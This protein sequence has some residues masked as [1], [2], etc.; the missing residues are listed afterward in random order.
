MNGKQ[1]DNNIISK[2]KILQTVTKVSDLMGLLS[3]FIIRAKILM[4]QIWI[5]NY[6]CDENLPVDLVEISFKW[7]SG[8]WGFSAYYIPRCV[9]ENSKNYVELHIFS[10]ACPQAYGAVAYLRTIDISNNINCNVLVA[11]NSVSPVD[12]KGDKE[13]TLPELEFTRAL[14]A[15]HCRNL[16]LII[17]RSNLIPV[18]CGPTLR[19]HLTGFEVKHLDRNPMLAIGW[20]RRRKFLTV[21]EGI[22]RQ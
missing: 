16:L 13:L 15:A 6:D 18:F 10:D 9:M 22:A 19:L 20:W 4:Q 3:S 14:C 2:R 12:R 21:N 8:L 11:K 5:I 17:W 7:I 1:T